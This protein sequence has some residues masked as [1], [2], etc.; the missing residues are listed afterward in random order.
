[1]WASRRVLRNPPMNCTN[2]PPDSGPSRG[3]I[4]SMYG[5]C[6]FKCFNSAHYFHCSAFHNKLND[7]VFWASEEKPP[8]QI[9][10][11]V[12]SKILVKQKCTIYH[13]LPRCKTL[14]KHEV[15]RCK[16][17]M[18]CSRMRTVCCSGRWGWLPQCMLGYV[19][20]K[21]GVCPSACWDMSSQGAVCPS[22]C[23]DMSAEGGVCP[24]A[25][26]GIHSPCEQNDRRLWKHNLSATTLRTVIRNFT[27][28]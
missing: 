18:H 9:I 23:W 6:K 7:K 26:T 16:T 19:C 21:G 3:D 17:R 1:M 24:S 5:L 22:A 11:Y 15:K 10:D 14:K 28:S 2:V 8:Y 27:T 25:L 4:P 20:P 12:R 13:L